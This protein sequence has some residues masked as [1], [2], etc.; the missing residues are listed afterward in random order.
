[1]VK[2]LL[3]VENHENLYKNKNNKAI[4][5][6]DRQALEEFKNRKQF[7]K[8]LTTRMDQLE[9]DIQK[10]YQIIESKKL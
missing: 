8:A 10:L 1:M 7:F 6:N 4:L 2:E 3:R 5:N 9:Q